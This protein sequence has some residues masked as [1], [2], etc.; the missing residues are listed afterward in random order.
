MGKQVEV[1]RVS[2]QR[3]GAD[4]LSGSPVWQNLTALLTVLSD[5]PG[6]RST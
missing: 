4:G 1:S 2:A 5:D 6:L 3:R